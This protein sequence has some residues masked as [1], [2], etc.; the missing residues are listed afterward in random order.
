MPQIVELFSNDRLMPAC[1]PDLARTAACGPGVSQTFAK[2]AVIA[3]GTDNLAYPLSDVTLANPTTALVVTATGSDGTLDAGN[4]MVAYTLNTA[5]GE[6]LINTPVAVV[7]GATNH[8]VIPTV[9]LPSGATSM[10]LYLAG[11]D[12]AEFTLIKGAYNGT[13]YNQLAPAVPADADKNPPTVNTAFKVTNA[14]YKAFGLNLY[15]CVSDANGVLYLGSVTG[16][17]YRLTGFTD[18]QV[19]IKGCFNTADLSGWDANVFAALSAR[20]LGPGLI[21]I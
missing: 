16:P 6:T 7:V 15:A 9:T 2:G 17:S 4:Y 5:N 12:S 18:L 3:V 13:G 21:E 8:L 1:L 19:Y 10:N 14:E 20:T 11:P